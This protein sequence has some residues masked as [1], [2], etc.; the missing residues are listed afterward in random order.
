MLKP[1][2]KR[3]IVKVDPIEEV[4]AGGIIL[5]KDKVKEENAS[6]RGTIVRLSEDCF[7]EYEG[8]PKVGDSVYFAKYAGK[9]VVD[10]ED[11]QKYVIL[12]DED[13]VAIIY[14]NGEPV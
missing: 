4:S 9:W 5:A 12:N 2:F 3:L 13:V 8:L 1:I 11:E 10:P 14:K 6:E 7:D